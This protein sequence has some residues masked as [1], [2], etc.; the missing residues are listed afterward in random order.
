MIKYLA[1]TAILCAGVMIACTQKKTNSGKAVVTLNTSSRQLDT[2]WYKH[3]DSAAVSYLVADRP[4]HFTL[5]FQ[6]AFPCEV[7]IGGETPARWRMELFLEDGDSVNIDKSTNDQVSFSG[8]GA[9]KQEILF[10]QTERLYK[11]MEQINWNQVTPDTLLSQLTRPLDESIAQLEKERQHVSPAFYEKKMI[12]FKYD[13]LN[14]AISVPL[15]LKSYSPVK[16]ADYLPAGYWDIE[17][18]I[19][20]DEKLLSNKT[21]ANFM[22][23]QYIYFLRRKQATQTGEVDTVFSGLP[24]MKKDYAIIA[25]LYTG[26]MRSMALSNM[27]TAGFYNLKNVAEAKPLMETYFSQYADSSDKKTVLDSYNSYNKTSVGQIPP[28]FTLKDMDGKPVTLKDFAGKVV[29]MDFWASWCSPC[30]GEM[31]QGS[32][33]LHAKFKDEKNVV[34]LYISIDDKI[35]AWKEAIAQDKIE[36]VHLLS[37]GG[38][39]SEIVK[40]FN[41][42]GVPH[43]MLIGK[44]GKILDNDAPRPSQPETAD[45]IREALKM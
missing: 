28:P 20:I 26:K 43:Y 30:R 2:I 25:A 23:F 4:G 13:R 35:D 39:Q 10:R 40:A 36:G 14:Y 27:F 3:Q 11:M 31:Q 9:M 6:P 42:G 19:V 15:Y 34:F 45:K 5:S 33:G 18:E 1:L 7:S 41:I 29:Y 32:P 37:Q 17:K 21:Y 16:L 12:D 22:F 38:F 44:D 8:T 24:S